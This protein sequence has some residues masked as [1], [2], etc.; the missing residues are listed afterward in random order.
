MI[1]NTNKD[2]LIEQYLLGE[3]SGDLLNEFKEKL[4]ADDQFK[5]DVAMQ[6]AFIRNIKTTG[7]EEWTLKL[8][9]IHNEMNFAG[10]KAEEKP[11]A[12]KIVP[13]KSFYQKKY[14]LAVAASIILIIFSTFLLINMNN[15]PGA[16]RVFQTF[17]QPYPDLEPD[18]RSFPLSNYSVKKDAFKAY[19]EGNYLESIQLFKS[20]LAQGEDEIVLFYLGNAYLSADKAKEAESIFQNYLNNY[21]EFAPESKWYL[22]LSYLKQGKVNEARKLL[23]EL[24]KGNKDYS[25]KAGDVLNKM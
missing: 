22:S 18:T 15:R 3:L 25:K 21:T 5:K 11:V 14:Y 4:A 24:F 1:E 2:E 12:K 17:Y 19:N 7:R 23:E 9:A 6:S 8:K 13:L 10:V 20:I 16:E